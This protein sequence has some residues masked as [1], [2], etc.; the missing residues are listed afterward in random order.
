MSWVA[1]VPGFTVP[2]STVV[3]GCVHALSWYTS[4]FTA[5][6]VPLR[7]TSREALSAAKAAIVNTTAVKE[8][9]NA[10]SFGEWLFNLIPQKCIEC[11]KY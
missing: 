4:T 6:N 10:A 5:V 1:E 8:T 7:V 11:I 3:Q 9:A 2:T